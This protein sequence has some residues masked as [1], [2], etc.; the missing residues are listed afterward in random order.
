[1]S[2]PPTFPSAAS[3]SAFPE[4]SVCLGAGGFTSLEDVRGGANTPASSS[5]LQ[6]AV[7]QTEPALETRAVPTGLA[8]LVK[9]EE[10]RFK[11]ER[12]ARIPVRAQSSGPSL[13]QCNQPVGHALPVR[14]S[15]VGAMTMTTGTFG[16]IPTSQANS[17]P[18]PSVP[19]VGPSSH[20]EPP[21]RAPPVNG[22]TVGDPSAPDDLE[23]DQ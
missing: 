14:Q 20:M 9:T 6:G 10:Q 21:E 5:G 13:R 18:L 11:I 8:S 22:T 19:H 12:G 2:S 16:G 17:Q 23:I 4:G 3:T 1:M 15:P 7:A